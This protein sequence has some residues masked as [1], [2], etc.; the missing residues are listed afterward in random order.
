M[1]TDNQDVGIVCFKVYDLRWL[2]D[3]SCKYCNSD[4]ASFI[5]FVV[6]KGDIQL[7]L[8]SV[9]ERKARLLTGLPASKPLTVVLKQNTKL[10]K[11]SFPK[12]KREQNFC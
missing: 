5:A 6:R 1:I 11:H 9:G 3:I 2:Y 12:V 10:S 8:S 7:R 4:S